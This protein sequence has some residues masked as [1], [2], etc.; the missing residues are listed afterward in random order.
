MLQPA[1][2]D[3]SDQLRPVNYLINSKQEQEY[4]QF[5]EKVKELRNNNGSSDSIRESCSR[6]HKNVG[7]TSST[8]TNST[9]G[10][11]KLE[12][13][14]CLLE[15]LHGSPSS[16][17]LQKWSCWKKKKLFMEVKLC[18]AAAFVKFT[19]PIFKPRSC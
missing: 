11:K 7:Q 10:V 16:L 2:L 19:V 5:T 8:Q 3:M 18:E 12:L 4:F 6:W 17:L 13:S 1:V 14:G 15:G 9:A